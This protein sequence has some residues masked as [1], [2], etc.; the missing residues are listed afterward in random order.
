MIGDRKER[1]GAASIAYLSR[2][3]L[4]K[5]ASILCRAPRIGKKER[6]RDP[7]V[8][9]LGAIRNLLFLPDQTPAS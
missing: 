1:P 5:A 8:A 9:D 6:T 4:A 3:R 2:R 7:H